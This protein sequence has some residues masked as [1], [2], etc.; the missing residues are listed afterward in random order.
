V[1][2]GLGKVRAWEKV[3]DLVENGDNAFKNAFKELKKNPDFLK[4][5]NDVINDVNVN[6]HIFKGH[7]KK[8]IRANGTEYWDAGGVHSKKAIDDSHAAFRTTPETIGPSGA[9]YYTAKIKLYDP[10]FPQNGG[11]KSKSKASTFFPDFWNKERIQAEIGRV[12]INNP[13]TKEIRPDGSKLLGGVMSDGVEL[14][15][16]Q[17]ADGSLISAFPKFN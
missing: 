1:V 4:K 16:W 15:I 12:L 10:I 8:K 14:R 17:N 6:E 5:F 2:Q 3:D 13:I 7:I 9:G 11:W